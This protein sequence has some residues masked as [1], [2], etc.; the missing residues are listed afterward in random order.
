MTAK[1]ARPPKSLP[2][3][4]YSSALAKAVE[5]LGDRYL[6]AIPIK[7]AH[8]S[9]VDQHRPTV[10]TQDDCNLSTTLSE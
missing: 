2:V 3:A 6:L 10:S 9:G 5:W 7:S 8:R 4:N 1:R